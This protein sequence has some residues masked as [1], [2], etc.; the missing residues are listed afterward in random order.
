MIILLH[1][2][3]CLPTSVLMT[4]V[5]DK[6]SKLTLFLFLLY[7]W[8]SKGRVVTPRGRIG[9]HPVAYAVH[10][11]SSH[12]ILTAALKITRSRSRDLPSN[13]LPPRVA[14][15]TLKPRG[16][17]TSPPLSL[18]WNSNMVV[19]S[20][21]AVPKLA[22]GVGGL[23]TQIWRTIWYWIW[24]LHRYTHFKNNLWRWYDTVKSRDFEERCPQFKSW[25]LHL[26]V[27]M[28]LA[29]SLN[30]AAFQS[31]NLQNRAHHKIYFIGMW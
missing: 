12:W 11:H 6:K 28:D 7:R 21:L 4:T 1:H 26:N 13:L 27:E 16:F 23:N 18:Q 2:S 24:K 5:R 22:V 9:S 25:L 10:C 29:K 31:P 15:L 30:F 14:E 20:E 19:K 3:Q 8:G 17:N